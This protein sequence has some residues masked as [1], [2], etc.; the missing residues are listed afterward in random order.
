MS[1]FVTWY[2]IKYLQRGIIFEAVLFI[3]K[4]IELLAIFLPVTTCYYVHFIVGER[5]DELFVKLLL[6]EQNGFKVLRTGEA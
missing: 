2:H 5:P 4:Q 6:F 3:V 1:L